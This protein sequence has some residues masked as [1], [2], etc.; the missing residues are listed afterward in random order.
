MRDI[1]D[2]G[3][4]PPANSLR[5]SRDEVVPTAP[6]KLVQCADCSGVQLTAT[7][8]PEFLFSRYVWVTAT[9]AT[10]RSYSEFFCK[11]VLKRI[12][13]PCPFVVEIASNDG[14]FLRRFKEKN[15]EVLGVDPAKNIAAAAT[16]TG[17]PTQPE[18]FT[19]DLA[20]SILARSGQPEVV[21][22]RNVI[23]HVA[24]IH[25]IVKGLSLLA[26]KGATVA[27]EFHYAK[28]IVDE[29][30]YDSI[31]HEHLFYFSLRSLTLLFAQYG[32]RPFDVFESP[33]SGGSLVIFFSA[34]EL[35]QTDALSRLIEVEDRVHLNDI[36][37]WRLF[38]EASAT[39][40]KQL[41]NLVEV[42]ASSKPLIAYG[43][44]ARSSTL[45]NFAGISN[46]HIECVIDRNPLK[47]GLFTP[48][49]DIPIVSFEDGQNRIAGRDVLLL[50]WNF[51]EEVVGD[52]RSD[53]FQGDIIVPLP[54]QIHI[55]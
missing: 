8:D 30:H 1:L 40:A 18:F 54:N 51:E 31:Y 32:L 22:A 33:I 26:G 12:A 46:K 55:R 7:V 28:A 34:D 9:S 24:E 20:Q 35:Q 4:Q 44:S 29:L 37:K 23:P 13:A 6:L 48:G 50:A 39:H 49:T 3:N 17:I 42:R 2:L 21:I 10:A 16:A 52:L 25:S 15:C 38:G 11:E 45:M 43:A 19:E 36:G 41:K 47:Q 27:I 14:T 53:G 5:R